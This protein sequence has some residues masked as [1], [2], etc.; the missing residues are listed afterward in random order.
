MS[1]R[2][3]DMFV[4]V[5]RS[6][7]LAKYRW[8]VSEPFADREAARALTREHLRQG[9]IAYTRTLRE[10]EVGGVPD[11]WESGKTDAQ[12]VEQRLVELDR[13]R[14]EEQYNLKGLSVQDLLVRLAE[15]DREEAGLREALARLTG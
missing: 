11:T 2:G 6:G 8:L 15:L 1:S 4:T 14:A 5:Y 3:R 12:C 13:E 10:V 7:T 9:Q